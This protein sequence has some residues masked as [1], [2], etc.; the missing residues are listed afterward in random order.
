MNHITK[1]SC[2]T[3]TQENEHIHRCLTPHRSPDTQRATFLIGDSHA[4]ALRDGLEEAVKGHM[5]FS[6]VAAAGWGLNPAQTS[7]A[8][9]SHLKN[10]M[11]RGDVLVYTTYIYPRSCG[12]CQYAGEGMLNHIETILLPWIREK[13]AHLVLVNDDP[14]LPKDARMCMRS[15]PNRC[16][17]D[18]ASYFTGSQPAW[19]L[20]VVPENEEPKSLRAMETAI[21]RF[22]KRHRGVVYSFEQLDLW[23]D[24][25]GHGSNIIPG[26]TTNGYADGHHLSKEGSL[27]LAPYICAAFDGWGFFD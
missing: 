25:Q 3:W 16:F 23:L 5:A 24:A 2:W 19:Q 8:R 1:A 14:Q 7:D 12:R 11:R 9:I 6:Y 21:R 10:A 20:G 18:G 4:G 26:T 15:P 22:A 27:Y 17:Y 13:G